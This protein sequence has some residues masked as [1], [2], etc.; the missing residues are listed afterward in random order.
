M[1]H[2]QRVEDLMQPV[3]HP[4]HVEMTL[5]EAV[6]LILQSGQSGLP[7]VD[8]EYRVCGFV[9]EHD[10]VGY[11][12]SGSYHCD[13]RIQVRDIM[14]S[15]PLCASPGENII[16]QVQ[17]MGG[18]KPKTWPVVGKDGRLA[19]VISRRSIMRA[20]NASMKACRTR[21]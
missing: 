12:I 14:F 17:K 19:G 21:L 18:D 13:S 6:D 7:V 5:A 8:D 1:I 9:S 15:E 2:Q 20:L 16:D 11:L 3:P 10:C 4:L